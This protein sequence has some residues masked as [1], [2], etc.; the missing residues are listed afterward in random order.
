MS[1]E[2][3]KTEK[4]NDGKWWKNILPYLLF[5]ALLMAF[6]GQVIFGNKVVQGI[7][8]NY[9]EFAA[10]KRFVDEGLA[11]RWKSTW[12]GASGLFNIQSNLLFV[13]YLPL[14]YAIPVALY[15]YFFT[16]LVFTYLLL[17]KFKLHT[18]G[19]AFG[20]FAFA[21]SPHF[22]TLIYPMHG[23]AITLLAYIPMLFFFLTSAFEKV[24]FG[25]IQSWRASLLA[26]LAWGM[27]MNEEPQR[28]I[29]ISIL[30]G[31]YSVFLIWAKVAMKPALPSR[32][33]SRR[34]LKYVGRVALIGAVLFLVFFHNLKQQW[35]GKNLEG[36][37]TGV[38]QNQSQ[39]VEQK[40]QFATSWS[41]NPRELADSLA[42]GYHGSLSNDPDQPYWGARPVAHSSDSLGFFVVLFGILGA[43]AGFRRDRNVRFFVVA[44]ILATLLAFGK[45]LPGRPLFWLWYQLPMMDKFRAP[46]KFMCVTAFSLSILAGFGLQYLINSLRENSRLAG[47]FQKALL[48]L[49]GIGIV[50]FLYLIGNEQYLRVDVLAKKLGGNEELAR[51]AFKNALL[52]VLRMDVYIFLSII[53][54]WLAR[55]FRNF[56]WRVGIAAYVFALM[57]VFDLFSIDQFYLQKSL[58]DPDKFFV[59]DEVIQTIQS[60]KEPYRVTTNLKIEHQGRMLPLSLTAVGNHY[61]T[62]LFPY[63]QIE[64]FDNTPQSRVASDYHTFFQ[65]MLDG[66]PNTQNPNEL[67]KKLLD[68]NIRLWRLCNVKYLITDGHL[69]G[70][71]RRPIP[72]SEQLKRHPDLEFVKIAKG[73]AGR[74]QMV[75]QVR[76]PLPRFAFYNNVIKVENGSEAL[77]ILDSPDFDIGIGLV[78]AHNIVESPNKS[79]NA[80]F[81]TPDILDY[82]P[83][84]ARIKI[85]NLSPGILMIN[86]RY[87]QDWRLLIDGELADTL[88][89]NFIMQSIM[90]PEGEHIIEFE[91]ESDSKT[92]K[93]SMLTAFLVLSVCLLYS[94]GMPI[95]SQLKRKSEVE[96]NCGPKS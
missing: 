57:L 44:A 50:W 45:Y 65:G 35:G 12:L 46:A 3:K 21:F 76:D 28:G 48:A 62:Y 52:A 16:S 2:D 87:N 23:G 74:Q 18:F 55:R 47:Y 86:S 77:Q 84:S 20:A 93:I 19:A 37:V 13:K 40:W 63:F 36:T 30:A 6:F 34:N 68:D 59:K 8:G 49:L 41:L 80:T 56:P 78:V 14:Q 75:F 96:K 17:R 71:S 10:I 53:T 58:I 60:E 70:L 90:L 94:L 32:D 27:I 43:V 7:D 5:A 64:S 82:K 61:I 92:L 73:F 38:E 79:V 88:K 54:L 22:A 26:G 29:Y 11:G 81:I 83:S 39:N 85:H 89:A 51:T 4:I 1:A 69:Y 67:V 72:I 66:I 24:E 31:S 91:Y 42:P 9:G 15:C 95:V 33:R 25:S